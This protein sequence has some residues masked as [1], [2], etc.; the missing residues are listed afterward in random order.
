MTEPEARDVGTARSGR[1]PWPIRGRQSDY[2]I[3][4][5]PEVGCLCRCF[6]FYRYL[7]ATFEKR[8][9]LQILD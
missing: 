7:A 5:L 8:N 2:T 9:Q 1:P 4:C 3:L 6:K